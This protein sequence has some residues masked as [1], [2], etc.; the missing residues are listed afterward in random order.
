MSSTERAL[1]A[2][3][4]A[5]VSISASSASVLQPLNSSMIAV[6]MV[7][8]VTHFGSP[9][10]ASWLISGMYIATAV[11]APIGG[12]L[13]TIFGARRIYLMGL[14]IV[15]VAT[16]VGS[17]APDINWLIAAYVLLGIGMATHFP[18][19]MTIIRD[20]ADRHRSD[21]KSALLTL[22]LCSQ[23]VAALGPT[24]GGLLVGTFGWQS[25]LWINLPVIALSG[26][27]VLRYV[28]PDSTARQSD[29]RRS[30]LRSLDLL[31]VGLFV[32]LTSTTMMF[33]L[34][35]GGSPPWFLLAVPA[36]A[37]VLFVV[38]EWHTDEPFIDVRALA[39]NRSLSATLVRTLLTYVAFYSVFFSVPQWLQYQRGMSATQT[40]LTMLPVAAVGILSTYVASK[41]LRRC[42][43]RITLTVGSV[44]LTAGGLLLAIVERTTAPIVVV[45]L[46]AA[47]LGVPSGFNNL[48]NQNMVNSAT[49]LEEVGTA[50]GM[51]RTVQFLG[52]NLA[53]VV[54]Q[55][56]A[57]PSV[58]D[59]GIRHTGWVVVAISLVLLFGVA[60]TRSLTRGERIP[61]E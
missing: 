20:Y 55:F 19:A 2:A 18:N 44:A 5:K 54:L 30:L 25:I 26:A 52:A 17:F 48:S 38:R 42:G 24:V 6:A 43:P 1:G 23:S 35:A 61:R 7:A 33:L 50:M 21:P 32:V 14:G 58:G 28:A 4:P 51:Y 34:S 37:L 22:V 40:G 27:A 16:V 8:I 29:S 12:K 3:V 56:T 57:G 13:G 31:G 47:V 46:V 59:D 39:H 10:G 41:V 36:I 9:A 15:G 45:L 49:S 53:A 11:S 60:V